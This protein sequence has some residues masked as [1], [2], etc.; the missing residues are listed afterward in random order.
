MKSTQPVVAIVAA[1]GSGSRLGADLP[2][3]L[4]PLNGKPII[5]LALEGLR[6]A[7]V[8]A[9]Y[10]AVPAEQ[11][12]QFEAALADLPM[13][14]QL[15]SGGPRR[16]DSVRLALEQLNASDN[17]PDIV[18]VHDAARPL[19]PVDA[20][21]RVIQAVAGGAK[22]VIPV[23]PVVDT[24]RQVCGD[25]SKVIDRATLRAVQTPQGFD[26]LV[27]TQAHE[28]PDLEGFTDD[29]AMCERLGYRVQLVRGSADSH[30]ITTPADLLWAESSLSGRDDSEWRS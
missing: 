14:V 23:I 17:P 26:R 10:V 18:L 15:V 9:A 29:A 27:L 20:I 25:Q 1:A 24:V 2:K 11:I 21:G 7:G 12:E 28:Q 5:W 19:T 16:Q 6:R 3:A 30:K 13:Q 22:A 8:Q 4:V